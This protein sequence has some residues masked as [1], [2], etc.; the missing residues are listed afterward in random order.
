MTGG[1]RATVKKF[2]GFTNTTWPFEKNPFVE[3][4]IFVCT[5]IVIWILTGGPAVRI[6]VTSPLACADFELFLP[7]FSPQTLDIQIPIAY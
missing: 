7:L 6:H 2:D 5:E 1:S 4:T 3:L